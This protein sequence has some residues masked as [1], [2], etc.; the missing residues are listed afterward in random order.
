[1]RRPLS[2]M[3]VKWDSHLVNHL[4]SVSINDRLLRSLI[5]TVVM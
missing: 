5:K 3:V 4:E 2:Q 1:M